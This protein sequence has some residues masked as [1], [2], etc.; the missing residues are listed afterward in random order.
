MKKSD[1]FPL[2]FT[3]INSR[4][5]VSLRLPP[6]GED[7]TS[8][9]VVETTKKSDELNVES[10]NEIE[11]Y[12]EEMQKKIGSNIQNIS[13]IRAVVKNEKKEV[14]SDLATTI[15]E[16]ELANGFMKIKLQDFNP[17][18]KDTWNNFKAEFSGEMDELNKEFKVLTNAFSEKMY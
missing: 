3:A 5:V 4:S 1:L 14:N 11:N 15:F 16:L 2:A 17:S 10:L 18:G 6:A 8:E 12:R 13:E 9:T 7:T